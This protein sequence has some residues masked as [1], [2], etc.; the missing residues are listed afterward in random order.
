MVSNKDGY[1]IITLA[2]YNETRH[3]YEALEGY[4]GIIG[5]GGQMPSLQEKK[6]A[7]QKQFYIR[8]AAGVLLIGFCVWYFFTAYKNSEENREISKKSL[9]IL[10]FFGGILGLHKFFTGNYKWGFAYLFVFNIAYLINSTNETNP[11]NKKSNR[12]NTKKTKR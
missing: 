3:G 8:L 11:V 12:S 7:V 5:Q 6:N 2:N 9:L 1:L 10:T 4:L